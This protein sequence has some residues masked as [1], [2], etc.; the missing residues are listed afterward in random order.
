MFQIIKWI[1][2]N[3]DAKLVARISPWNWIFK[4]LINYNL[5]G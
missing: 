2:K 1:V 3:T 5:F 4:K